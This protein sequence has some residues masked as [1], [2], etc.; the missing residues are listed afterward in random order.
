ME[1]LPNANYIIRDFFK[2]KENIGVLNKGVTK[3]FWENLAD[4]G[5]KDVVT[6]YSE[7]ERMECSYLKIKIPRSKMWLLARGRK[8]TDNEEVM[9]YELKFQMD[10]E[11][12]LQTVGLL[13]DPIFTKYAVVVVGSHVRIAQAI[14][15]VSFDPIQYLEKLKSE[16]A[17]L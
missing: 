8:A 7:A 1:K 11:D 4:S 5:R 16:I 9:A 15:Q 2:D 3:G 17:K 10:S 12:A 6:E 14:N 13:D